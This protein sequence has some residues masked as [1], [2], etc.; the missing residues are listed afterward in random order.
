MSG[1]FSSSRKTEFRT[2]KEG[3]RPS[4]DAVCGFYIRVDCISERKVPKRSEGCTV[5]KKE[6]ERGRPRTLG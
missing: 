4:F 3:S 5:G 1:I 2:L 6:V